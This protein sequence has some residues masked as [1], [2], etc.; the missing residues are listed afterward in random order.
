MAF[1]IGSHRAKVY[2][3]ISAMGKLGLTCDEAIEDLKIPHASCSPT[4]TWLHKNGY[5][6]GTK[7]Y[8][9]TNTGKK[10]EVYVLS[11]LHG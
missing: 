3:T 1:K 2:D 11:E 5:I 9:K 4:F 8:R 6:V 7:Q 10:A